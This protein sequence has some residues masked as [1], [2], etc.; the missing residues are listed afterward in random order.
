MNSFIPKCGHG[1]ARN[2]CNKCSTPMP[3]N[4]DKEISKCCGAEKKVVSRK[5]QEE[6]LERLRNVVKD[7]DDA[8][9]TLEDIIS[10]SLT[11][12]K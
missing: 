6:I 3:N 8:R 12:S 1:Y 10:E 11:S 7:D 2:D 5:P 9:D 4:Q